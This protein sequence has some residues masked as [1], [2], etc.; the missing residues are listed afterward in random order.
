M[1]LDIP[2]ACDVNVSLQRRLHEDMDTC[3]FTARER[4]VATRPPAG[5][6]TAPYYERRAGEQ[7]LEGW[8]DPPM[9]QK[10]IEGISKWAVVL[11]LAVA[12][13]VFA[14]L[15]GKWEVFQMFCFWC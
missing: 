7:Q 8:R 4:V 11:V 6:S 10:A 15:H 2:R 9:G 5:E 1:Q 13:A 3:A 14:Y 12:F